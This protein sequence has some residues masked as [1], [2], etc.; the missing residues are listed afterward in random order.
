[1]EAAAETTVIW[2]RIVRLDCYVRYDSMPTFDVSVRFW[3]E[4]RRLTPA[5]R[6]LFG[7]ARRDFIDALRQWEDEGCPGRPR[8]PE[9]LGVKRMVGRGSIFELAWAPDGRCT[10]EYG[11]ARLSGRAHVTWRRIGSHS[12]YDEP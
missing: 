3:N 12:I 9:R 4:Y 6:V 10:W 1:M 7:A 2:R 11:R 5:Q 8:F